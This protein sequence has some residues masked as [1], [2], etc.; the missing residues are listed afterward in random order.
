MALRD[1]GKVPVAVLGLAAL[2]VGG[3]WLALMAELRHDMTSSRA[4]V[5]TQVSNL[6][7][8]F[9]EHVRRT[10]SE[11]DQALL[12]LRAEIEEEPGSL[13]KEIKLLR[14]SLSPHFILQI[15]MLD[16]RGAVSYS[17]PA[18][19]P[20]RTDLSD[21]TS[22]QA[23]RNSRDDV[24]L[25]SPPTLVAGRWLLEFSR[26]MYGRDG[27]FAGV[28]VIAVA[29]EHFTGF[30][31]SI[32][33]GTHGSI[34]LLG[35]DGVIRA[36]ATRT[37]PL[38]EPMGLQ[39]SNRPFLD[40]DQPSSG[41]YEVAAMVDG[42]IRIVAYRRLTHIPLTVLVSVSRDEAAAPAV[43]RQY[44]LLLG[45]GTVTVLL[46]AVFFV[47]AWLMARQQHFQIAVAR[48]AQ[49][50]Q[51]SN[52]EL[53]A[54]A[55]AISH[56]LREPLR[57]VNSF[58]SL[59]TRRAGAKLDSSETEFITF[60]R[61]GALRMDRLIVGLLEYSRI[62]RREHPFERVALATVAE[63]AVANLRGIIETSRATVRV[64]PGLPQ[65][66]GDG[67][68][69]L[70]LFQNLIGNALKYRAED[71]DPLIAIDC[72]RQ[73]GTWVIQVTD[74]GIGIAAEHFERIFGIFQRLHGRNEYD[75]CGIGL[76]LCR[77]I[78]EHHHGRIWLT[79]RE[80]EG[81]TFFIALPAIVERS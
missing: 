33:I 36:R 13:A 15:A 9:E 68:E 28:L 38:M 76:A 20:D 30:Y 64:T 17:D 46:I 48:Q 53:E 77:K 71:R 66:L 49:Q 75:G 73:A 26:G 16:A 47:I 61:D 45:G 8:A 5:E 24:L 31:Q 62:G 56:D 65:I 11:I 6:A 29:P 25:V 22:L 54:F 43:E 7:R 14:G 12:H 58:L 51:R 44:L 59:L 21:R 39:L 32:D 41:V 74:N 40:P 81:S 23:H 78:V 34:M 19:P 72:E 50:L 1:W 18:M 70:R 10:T 35:H 52:S 69:L 3:L 42:M 2:L 55:Y 63:M 67:D 4:T 79:S 80:G 57:T 37:T 60:A 27:S